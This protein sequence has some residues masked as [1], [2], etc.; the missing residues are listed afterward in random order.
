MG[1]P[2]ARRFDQRSGLVISAVSNQR[3]GVGG[4]D[5]SRTRD[6]MNA[7]HARSQLRYWPTDGVRPLLYQLPT[8]RRSR[9]A[10]THDV[11]G[12]VN[13]NRPRTSAVGVQRRHV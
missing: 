9:S 4:P 2:I 7:I 5:G 11:Y 3:L 1:F 8:W 6:L 10:E 12:D 13:A